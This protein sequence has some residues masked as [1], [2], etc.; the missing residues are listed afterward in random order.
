MPTFITLSHT[1]V[2]THYLVCLLETVISRMPYSCDDSLNTAAVVWKPCWWCSCFRLSWRIT[3]SCTGWENCPTTW[4]FWNC[5]KSN[6]IKLKSA[7]SSSCNKAV[8]ANCWHFGGTRFSQRQRWY[9]P[10][11]R[12]W[13]VDKHKFHWNSAK[14]PYSST[15]FLWFLSSFTVSLKCI[16]FIFVASTQKSLCILFTT[17]FSW[18]VSVWGV[19][20]PNMTKNRWNQKLH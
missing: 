9:V 16:H 20:T 19:V 7:L 2:N 15:M 13:H 5:F 3:A 14:T 8:C 11:I 10:K 18:L 4:A 17:H 1:L 6:W 12:V